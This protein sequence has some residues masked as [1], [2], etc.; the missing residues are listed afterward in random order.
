MQYLFIFS[1]LLWGHTSFA[2][3]LDDH[4]VETANGT[5]VVKVME[6]QMTV[7]VFDPDLNAQ[8]PFCK[9]DCAEVWPPVLITEEESKNLGEDL[10]FVKRHNNKLQLTFKGRP[11]YTFF[12]D[13]LP[14]EAKGNG[15]GGVW[16]VIKGN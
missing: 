14:G 9:T 7:Y 12:A 13:R 2:L 4:Q 3:V 11:V 8:L 6:N 5:V 1:F 15:L 16:H 10:A